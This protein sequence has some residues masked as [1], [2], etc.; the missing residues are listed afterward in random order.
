MDQHQRR[1]YAL[2]AELG[3]LEVQK[4]Q[5]AEQAVLIE[6]MIAMKHQD[7]SSAMRLRTE[8]SNGN[9]PTTFDT[10]PNAASTAATPSAARELV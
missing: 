4:R 3:D 8:A 6:K 2:A 1:I 5:L 10:A 7:I 9:A